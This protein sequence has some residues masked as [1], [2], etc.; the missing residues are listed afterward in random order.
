MIFTIIIL[1]VI[2]AAL[3]AVLYFS[4]RL[5]LQ[6]QDKFEEI[7]EQ[8]DE[9]LDVLDACYQRAAQRAKLEVLSD[10]PVVRELLEDIKTTRD[11]ILLVANL[12]V[13]PMQEA[14]QEKDNEKNAN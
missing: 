6:N 7:S 13:K 10:E 4:L 9:S 3:S 14:E 12:I 8:I 11:A 2:C 5:N 1:S